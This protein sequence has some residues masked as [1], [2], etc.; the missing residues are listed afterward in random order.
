[1]NRHEPDSDHQFFDGDE[2]SGDLQGAFEPTL[3]LTDLLN[4]TPD[5][6]DP[7]PASFGLR[8]AG[9]EDEF[10]DQGFTPPPAA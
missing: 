9:M 3:S 4:R 2:T 5:L 7:C 8:L 1:M 10:G 6:L